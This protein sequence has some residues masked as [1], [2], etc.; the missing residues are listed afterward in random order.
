MYTITTTT[1][2]NEWVLRKI[3][4][5][6]KSALTFIKKLLMEGDRSYF[7]ALMRRNTA[8]KLD[9]DLMEDAQIAK[10]ISDECRKEVRE[11]K[12]S[13]SEMLKKKNRH[14]ITLGCLRALDFKIRKIFLDLEEIDTLYENCDVN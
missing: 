8:D 3:V 7:I 10:S 12:K 13:M 6:M 11:I 5:N 9:D 1:R 4:R 2:V 14:K